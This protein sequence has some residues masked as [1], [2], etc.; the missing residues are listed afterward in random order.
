MCGI[1]GDAYCASAW[2]GFILNLKH[3]VKF[4][5][6]LTIGKM[7]VFLGMIGVVAANSGTC[8]LLVNYAFPEEATQV[9]SPYSPVAAIA[10]ATL[11]ITFLFLAPFNDAVVATLLCFAVDM[12]LNNGQPQFGPPSY[13]EK[14]KE[15]EG[16]DHR[17]VVY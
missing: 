10:V 17:Q 13:Q 3:C 16:E 9:H 6:A 11:F 15:I 2:N 4:Y 8:Y 14:L 12:E 1:S 5:M 7:F